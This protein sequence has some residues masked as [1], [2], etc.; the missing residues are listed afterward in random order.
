MKQ[1]DT[2]LG[3]GEI[4][5]AD[6]LWLVLNDPVAH[7]GTALLVN[8][9]TLRPDAETTCILRSGEHEFIT[10]DSYVRYRS[11]RA[12]KTSDLEKLV[13]AGRLKLHRS[14]SKELLEKVR[15]GAKAS[16]QLALELKALL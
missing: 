9:S 13:R 4:H 8:L 16:P 3:G 15:A 2:F 7:E 1:G 12:A 5:G 6:H 10:R 14:A 11:A